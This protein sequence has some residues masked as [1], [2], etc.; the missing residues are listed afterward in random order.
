MLIL[1]MVGIL[2]RAL[3]AILRRAQKLG[4]G[5]KFRVQV[6]QVSENPGEQRVSVS[7][8]KRQAQGLL[9]KVIGGKKKK[10]GGA[11]RTKGAGNKRG[12]SNPAVHLHNAPQSRVGRKT[13][14]PRARQKKTGQQ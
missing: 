4:I 1:P 11:K 2:H 9:E 10:G 6:T 13:P 8:A 12:C 7:Q 14:S 3:T 5:R